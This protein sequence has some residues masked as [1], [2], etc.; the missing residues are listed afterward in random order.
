MTQYFDHKMQLPSGKVS[1]N[2]YQCSIV[3]P[4]RMTTT[5]HWT[6]LFGGFG[7]EVER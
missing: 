2:F 1:D 4:N 6:I 5:G 7:Q 3:N